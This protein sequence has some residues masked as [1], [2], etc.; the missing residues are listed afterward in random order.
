MPDT[1][2]TPS[3]DSESAPQTL[4]ELSKL[5]SDI[6]AGSSSIALG[7]AARH[8]LGAL[9]T[10]P[11]QAAFS[12]IS[13]LAA[14]H[15]ISA[16]TLSRLSRRLG[17][18]GFAQ[19][20]DVFRRSLAHSKGFYSDQVSRLLDNE[21]AQDGL[22]RMN[23]LARQESANLADLAATIDAASLAGSAELLA[24]A[25]RVRIHGMRQ[26]GSLAMFMAYGLGML[27]SDVAILDSS[28]QGIADALAQLDEGD[29]LVVASCYPYTPSVL[30]TADIAAQH[31]IRVIAMTDAIGSPL[32][33]S[34]M[35]SF[36]VPNHSLF[37]SNSMCAF[38]LLVEAL[39]S[40]VA[41]ML[42]DT[43]LA[44]LKRREQLI[45]ELKASL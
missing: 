33:T 15:N 16:S 14:R 29:V 32:C 44:A 1:S 39:L 27:R 38:M 11:E 10:V 18:Q 13:E 4:S 34:A 9:L 17:Y 40:E 45:G 25:R 30:A 28:R 2:E 26:F 43:G 36:Q 35:Y 8:A 19:L 24:T 37:F 21:A 20:Q 22:A 3:S 23:R 6:E 7:K 42:G 31:G 12:T 41:S 5:F